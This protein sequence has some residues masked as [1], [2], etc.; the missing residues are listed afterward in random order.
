MSGSDFDDGSQRELYLTARAEWDE[1]FG[2]HAKEKRLWMAI[3]LAGAIV[4][5]FGVAFG[6]YQATAVKWKPYVIAVDDLNARVLAPLPQKISDWEPGLVRREVSSFVEKLRSVTP[7]RTVQ[8]E[9]M[10]TVFAY[11]DRSGLATGKAA[12]HFRDEETEPL[13]RS[14]TE[15]VEVDVETVTQNSINTWAVEWVETVFERNSGEVR[16]TQRFRGTVIVA[17]SEDID[18]ERLR[19]NPL[20]IVVVDYDFQKVGG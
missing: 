8:R 16:G 6:A 12:R 7:D 20:G 1:R 4:G 17:K 9:R 11:L 18:Q 14:A 10:F 19:R 13:A 15:T 3:G 5:I 2:G